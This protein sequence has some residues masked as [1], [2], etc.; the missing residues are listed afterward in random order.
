M[1]PQSQSLESR[2]RWPPAKARPLLTLALIS[3]LCLPYHCGKN[4]VKKNLHCEFNYGSYKLGA[5]INDV[6][7]GGGIIIIFV[8]VIVLFVC[9]CSDLLHAIIHLRGRDLIFFVEL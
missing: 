1:G 8:T 3:L 2:W 7:Q 5:Y 9:S 6:K 4:K